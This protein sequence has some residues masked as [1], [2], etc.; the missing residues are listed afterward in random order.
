[1]LIPKNK[2]IRSRKHR[3]FIAS[4]PCVITGAHD[5][6]AAH[7]RFQ[8]GG[9]MGLKPSDEYCLP[10]S[11]LEHALQHK[12]G[13]VKYWEQYGGIERAKKLAKDLYRVSGDR[14]AAM[15]LIIQWRNG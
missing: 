1:M 9:G 8:N 4:L 12:M 5:V 10:L 7:L 14:E 2:P 15:E 11:C 13:E 3:F 6:Q